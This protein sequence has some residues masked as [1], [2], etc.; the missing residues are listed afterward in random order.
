M[1]FC[2]KCRTQIDD[3]AVVCTNCGAN[4]L[5]VLGVIVALLGCRDNRYAQ[6]HIRTWLKLEICSVI[7]LIFCIIPNLRWIAAGVGYIII[8]VLQIICFFNV[9][10]GKAIDPAII[11]GFGFLK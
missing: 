5:G 9:C 6:F 10:N 7:L 4:L 2:P 1:K 8:F 11:R 3:A